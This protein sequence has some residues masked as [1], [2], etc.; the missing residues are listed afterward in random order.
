M[1]YAGYEICVRQGYVVLGEDPL[2]E[3]VEGFT[4]DIRVRDA[5]QNDPDGRVLYDFPF[6]HTKTIFSGATEAEAVAQATAYIDQ[7]AKRGA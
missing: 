3:P 2:A 5:E 1:E 6:D 4:C 7:H